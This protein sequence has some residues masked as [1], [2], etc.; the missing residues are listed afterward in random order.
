MAPSYADIF[1]GN[2]CQNGIAPV[3]LPEALVQELFRRSAA[4]PG[5]YEL[6]VDSGHRHHGIGTALVE[7]LAELAKS[8]G[9]YGMWVLTDDDNDAALATYESAGA[10]RTSLSRMLEWEW[11]KGR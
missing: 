11:P 7:K 4:A 6:G 5:G 1:F 2:C 8:K 9:C 10:R 3:V